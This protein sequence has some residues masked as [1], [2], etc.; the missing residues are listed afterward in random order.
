MTST[1]ALALRVNDTILTLSKTST[2]CYIECAG[3]GGVLDIEG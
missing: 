3:D 1:K 2:L